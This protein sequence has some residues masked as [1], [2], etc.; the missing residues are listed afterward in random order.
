[1]PSNSMKYWN[2]APVH[3]LHFTRSPFTDEVDDLEPVVGE[4]PEL[5]HVIGLQLQLVRRRILEG[6]ERM[7]GGGLEHD[8]P[9]DRA[10][11]QDHRSED[12]GYANALQ[13]VH[14]PAKVTFRTGA[15]LV[16]Q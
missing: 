16:H 11:G 4:Q 10:T 6:V 7:V 12:Q 15:I 14:I 13:V 3:Q 1:M 5:E 8:V 9:V 2:A